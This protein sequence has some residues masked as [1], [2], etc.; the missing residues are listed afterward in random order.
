MKES[1][2]RSIFHI[3]LIFYL[4]LFGTLIAVFC[5]CITYY[6]VSSKW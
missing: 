4:I 3:Y 1:D 2:Y 6:N 5:F